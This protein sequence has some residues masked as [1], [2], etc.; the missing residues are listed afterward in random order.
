MLCVKCFGKMK[1]V[2]T[3]QYRSGDQEGNFPWVERRVVCLSCGH[4]THTVEITREL[5]QRAFAALTDVTR[6]ESAPDEE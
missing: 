4:R 3:R 1:T 2:D 6:A 5:W